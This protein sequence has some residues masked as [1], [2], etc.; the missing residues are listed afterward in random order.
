MKKDEQLNE[1]APLNNNL[2]SSTL[3]MNQE[4]EKEH[5]KP[6]VGKRWRQK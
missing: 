4:I 1:K 5:K 3:Q 6:K 2:N